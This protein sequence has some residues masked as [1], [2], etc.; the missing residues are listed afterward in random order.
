VRI[1][2]QDIP[3]KIDVP[4]AVARQTTDFGDPS[5]HGPLAAEY[6]SLGAG[7]D[8][9]PLLEGLEDDACQAPHWGYVIEGRL[10]VSYTDGTED[11]CAGGDVFY[12][13]AGHSVRA[14]DDAELILFSPHLEHAA[15]VDHVR[16]KLGVA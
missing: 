15:V 10:V 3:T 13:P 1:A 16:E 9:A 6:F 7:T 2:K 5:K 8:I 4:G 12:W 11:T 14:V